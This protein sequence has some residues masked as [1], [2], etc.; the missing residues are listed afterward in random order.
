M[1][2]FAFIPLGRDYDFRFIRVE[3]EEVPTTTE[4]V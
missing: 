1:I 3:E 2:L 4:M